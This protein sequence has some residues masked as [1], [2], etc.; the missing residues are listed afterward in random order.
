MNFKTTIVLAILAVAGGLFWLVYP[1]QRRNVAST[2]TLRIL[3]EEI[4]PERLQRIEVIYHEH[5][6]VVFERS[7]DGEWTMPGNGPGP[8]GRAK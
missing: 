8:S 2:E 4:K 6:A 5:S 3:E 7:S 1:S